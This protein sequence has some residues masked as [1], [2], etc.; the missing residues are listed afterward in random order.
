MLAT[1]LKRLNCL[2]LTAA[3]TACG[4]SGTNTGSKNTVFTPTASTWQSGVFA[5]ESSYKDFCAAPRAGT[6]PFTRQTYPDKTGTAMQEKMWLRSWSNNTYLWYNEITDRDPTSY[7]VL[8]YFDLLKTNQRTASN[9]LKDNFHFY[10]ATDEY[11]TV[12]QSG[13]SSEYGINWEFGSTRVPRSL[14]VRFTEAGSPAAN[15]GVTRGLK[16]NKIDNI[17]FINTNNSNN[18][19]RINEALFPSDRG[20]SHTFSFT[21]PNNNNATVEVEL[22]SANIVLDYVPQHKII[23]LAQGTAGYVQFNAFNRT[24]QQ[25]LIDAF[26]EFSQANVSE[27]IIDLRYNGGGLLAMSSQLAYMVAGEA[28]TNN[29]IFETT[30]FNDK[31]QTIDPITKN[32]LEPTPFYHRQIDWV[33]STFTNTLPSLNLA[34]VFVLT[35]DSTCSASEAFINGLRGINVDVIQIGNTTCGKPY[36]FYPQDNCGTTYFTVQFKGVNDKGFGEYSDGFSPK[37]NPQFDAEIKGCDV[38][39]D[40]TQALGEPSEALLANALYYAESGSCRP[41]LQTVKTRTLQSEQYDASDSIAIKS[42]N[43]MLEHNKIYSLITDANS[44]QTS[45]ED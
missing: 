12:S 32:Q 43:A 33:S 16:L 36:G 11:N 40:F 35:T 28:Q 7:N 21:D 37:S 2:L 6:D 14:T 25:D 27:L 4:G 20:L 24:A 19:D 38:D 30:Q 5:N 18:I 34:R 3:L 13:V 22:T 26:D 17:D 41:Q 39:D 10:Q 1:G 44:E 8:E 23:D 31:H 42:P 29:A 9:A 15:A 45:K